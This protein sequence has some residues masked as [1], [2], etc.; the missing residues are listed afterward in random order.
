[1]G[2]FARVAASVVPRT[3]ETAIAMG[4]AVDFE[5][6]TLVSEEGMYAAFEAA[7][8]WETPEPFV[9]LARII[10]AGGASL[11]FAKGIAAIWRDV[12]MAVPD[13]SAALVISHS[14]EIEAALVVCFPD[15]EHAA[16]GGSFAPCEGALL[17]FDGD[18]ARFTGDTILREAGI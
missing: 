16:W 2:P 7:R 9:A 11:T 14:G 8:W 12:V 3:R 5:I 15:A 18:P 13:G 17:T 10:S 1:M 6:V 4:F